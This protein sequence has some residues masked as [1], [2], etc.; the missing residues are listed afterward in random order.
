VLGGLA[1]VD[2]VARHH[3]RERAQAPVSCPKAALVRCTVLAGSNTDQRQQAQAGALPSMPSG[4]ISASPSIC[5]PPHMPSTVPPARVRGDGLVQPCARS[6]AR[7]AA[8]ALAGQHDPVGRRPAT[9][10]G[11]RAHCRRR[12]GTFLSGWNSSRLLMRG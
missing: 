7:S 6:Q 12:P 5:R 1:V 10:A 4:S 8:V 9:S 2:F 3:A 11:L